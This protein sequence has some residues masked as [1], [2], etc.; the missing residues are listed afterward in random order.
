LILCQAKRLVWVKKIEQVMRDTAALFWSRLGGTNVHV[1]IYLPG[2]GRDNLAADCYGQHQGKGC[3]AD[4]RG[5]DEGNERGSARA[6]V[7]RPVVSR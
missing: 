6:G 3:L 2:V 5:P 4:S 7:L 1:A